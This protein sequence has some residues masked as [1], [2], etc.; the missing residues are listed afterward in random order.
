MSIAGRTPRKS[1]RTA[2]RNVPRKHSSS[3]SY[4]RK[5]SNG[6]LRFL[7][8]FPRWVLWLLG[9]LLAACY[10]IFILQIVLHFSMPWRAM[11]GDVPEPDGYQIRGVDIS[12]YQR[13]ID[14]EKLRNAKLQGHP[15]RF[16]I[17]KATEGLAIFD[18]TFNDNFH[19]AQ[20]YGF[21]RGAYHF[22]IPASDAKGQADFFLSQ[23]H[24]MP[25]DLPPVLDVEKSGGLSAEELQKGV[26][27]WLRIV[28]NHYGTKP[29]IYT[30]YA[31][32]LKYLNT[33]EFNE[34]PFWI[35]HYYK[36]ELDYKG[37]WVMWQ[38]TDCGRVDGITSDVD[39]NVFNGSLSQLLHLCI[40]EEQYPVR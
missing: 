26:R 36:D 7:S 1:N 40:T 11:Y 15:V 27:E 18:N 5:K 16:V 32:K 3:S 33:P 6:F 25:G 19:K 2:A 24:L 13:H 14:W 30:N 12:H 31:F 22:F 37:D 35:A 9:S 4:K 20:K 8:R 29:I 21:V 28:G 17:I 38:Y 23:A 10:V 34:Y 39:C